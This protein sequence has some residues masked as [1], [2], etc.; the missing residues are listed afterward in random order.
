MIAAIRV[1][2]ELPPILEATAVGFVHSVFHSAVNIMLG[3]S[4]SSCN[5]CSTYSLHSTHSSCSTYNLHSTHSSYN[6]NNS[7]SACN[8][9]NSYT[10]DNY[11][12]ITILPKNRPLQPMSLQISSSDFAQFYIKEVRQNDY[13][14]I[15]NGVINIF[16]SEIIPEKTRSVTAIDNDRSASTSASGT[17]D[18]TSN[19]N[20]SAS[21]TNDSARIAITSANSANASIKLQI[22]STRAERVCL[23]ISGLNPGNNPIY[24]NNRAKKIFYCKANL[25]AVAKVIGASPM[26]NESI[27]PLLCNMFDGL[28][29]NCTDNIYSSFLLE[30]AKGLYKILSTLDINSCT[31]INSYTEIGQRF[32]GCGPGL[33]PSSDDFLCGV[34]A[35]LYGLANAGMLEYKTVQCVCIELAKGAAPNTTAISSAFLV[36]ASRGRFN[37]AV[38]DLVKACFICTKPDVTEALAIKVSGFG[39]TS[40]L[41]ILSGIWFGFAASNRF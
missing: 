23:E 18:S 33:T 9:N 40:G 8:S 20:D 32:A 13:I 10:S 12:M 22:D 11:R 19:T 35:S 34:F 27:A 36:N 1:A 37:E 2:L 39:A 5:S 17:S 24:N 38:L 21:N 26:K 15:E 16:Y 29:F 4:Y 14:A 6:L 25:D 3:G 28:P 41:D 31:D 30:R 7:N